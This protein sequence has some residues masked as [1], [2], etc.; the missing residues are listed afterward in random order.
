MSTLSLP[1]R[2]FAAI[3][4]TSY[5]AAAAADF[6]PIAGYTP[7]SDVVAQ[8]L[9]DLDMAEI[10]INTDLL[11]EAGLTAAWTAYSVGGNS[12]KTDEVRTIRDFSL[13]AQAVMTG[14]EWFDVYEDY[15]AAPDYADLFT[16]SAC[17]G[18]AD[19]SG[20]SVLTR[21][22]SCRGG[23]LYQNVW[24]QVIHELEDAIGDCNAG[25]L[26]ANDG[27]AHSWDEAWAF[28][29]GSTEGTEGSDEGYMLYALAESRCQNFATCTAD[30]DDSD[31]T[32]TSQVNADMLELYQEGQALLL[33]GDCDLAEAIID[34]V[35]DLMTVPLLQGML[36][37]FYLADP[38]AG[39]GGDFEQAQLWAHS[40]AALP[41]IHVCD[42][43]VATT[44]RANTD[45]NSADAP[46]KEGYVSLTE[47]LQSVYSC[48][49][50]SCSQVGGLVSPDATTYVDGLE[51]CSDLDGE[52]LDSGSEVLDSGGSD[53]GGHD[54]VLL[55]VALGSAAAV[56]VLAIVGCFLCMRKK[57]I[58]GRAA[59]RNN[60]REAPHAEGQKSRTVEQ[61]HPG[62][63]GDAPGGEGRRVIKT[64]H[65][66]EDGVHDEPERSRAT[67]KNGQRK[68]QNHDIEEVPREDKGRA[69]TTEQSGQRDEVHVEEGEGRGG[70]GE[71]NDRGTA[72]G[73][74]DP[75]IDEVRS[76]EEKKPDEEEEGSRAAEKGDQEE[77]LGAGAQSRGAEKT[78]SEQ[79]P[80][81]Q[82]RHGRP[83]EEKQNDPE[84]GG[85][86]KSPDA[87]LSGQEKKPCEED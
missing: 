55:G 32:G 2:A 5:V 14:E 69:L 50:V 44:I 48:L 51:P 45:I 38:L 76:D 8:S 78:G 24:M 40:A 83:G 19:F 66:V 54:M 84:P 74:E 20:A 67:Y 21:G 49:G 85:K 39:G 58:N 59:G 53:G 80:G 41:R 82:A 65:S 16:T 36:R 31:I 22:E 7:V 11:T 37:L 10:E 33:D 77:A 23:A 1:R 63:Q 46:V 42:P 15:W 75:T 47:R 26:S 72:P 64:E 81:E 73:Q 62:L 17:R 35:V 27:G 71:P 86:G 68:E 56:I 4:A 30:S 6:A 43:D 18:A 87:D 79:V 29:A 28:Y 52:V 70:A 25:D 12:L 57:R 60:Q 9:L 13:D 3:V 34:G 61:L